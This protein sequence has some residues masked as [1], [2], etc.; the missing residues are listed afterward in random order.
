M[1][2]GR[3]GHDG[4]SISLDFVPKPGDRVSIDGHTIVVKE[5]FHRDNGNF[6]RYQHEDQLPEY[7]DT[8]LTAP[9]YCLFA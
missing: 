1:N 2:K 7:A 3:R 9:L 5:V 4:K 8:V 6:I